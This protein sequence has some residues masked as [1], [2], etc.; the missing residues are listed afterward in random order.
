MDFTVITRGKNG[1]RDCNVND[2]L[3]KLQY[4]PHDAYCRYSVGLGIHF[5][6]T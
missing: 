5:T 3:Q 4:F 2:D 6:Q 1:R